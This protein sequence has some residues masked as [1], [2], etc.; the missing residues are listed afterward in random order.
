MSKKPK[1]DHEYHANKDKMEITIWGYS[2]S[3]KSRETI[4]EKLMA[5]L[6]GSP[7]RVIADAKK[8]SKKNLAKSS[9]VYQRR[10]GWPRLVTKRR[11]RQR[12]LL[13][14]ILTSEFLNITRMVFSSPPVEQ[15]TLAIAM[16]S[17]ASVQQSSPTSTRLERALR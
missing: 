8:N 9:M 1:I 17:S 10:L 13:R 12:I 4:I 16:S 15:A 2:S 6:E 5:Q 11:G 14:V 3:K 7:D